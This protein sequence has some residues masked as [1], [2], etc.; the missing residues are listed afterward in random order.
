MTIIATTLI[1]KRVL[2]VVVMGDSGGN[3]RIYLNRQSLDAV[4]NDYQKELSKLEISFRRILDS[5]NGSSNHHH[6]DNDNNNPHVNDDDT[7]DFDIDIET[8]LSSSSLTEIPTTIS[9]VFDLLES[10]LESIVYNYHHSVYYQYFSN[11]YNH[12][13]NNNDHDHDHG[14]DKHDIHQQ[15]QQQQQEQVSAAVTTPVSVYHLYQIITYSYKELST[16]L[17]KNNTYR[18]QE[19]LFCFSFLRRDAAAAVVVANIN[20][21]DSIVKRLVTKINIQI[22]NSVERTNTNTNKQQSK[23]Q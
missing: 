7:T 13:T 12:N 16:I 10:E 23:N 3:T 20:N 22:S 18:Q 1:R 11:N 15:H 4:I 14:D 21:P 19:V 5:N 17:R 2:A 9:A 6:H 8:V